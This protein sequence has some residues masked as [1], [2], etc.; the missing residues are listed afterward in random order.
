MNVIFYD[1]SKRNNS[2]KI[3]DVT[4]STLS[5]QIKGATSIFNPTLVILDQAAHLSNYCRIPDFERY[6]FVDN[7]TW[8]NGAWE[9]NLVCDV[10]ASYKY[11][12]E[13][14]VEY[15][16]RSS[17]TYDTNITDTAYLTKT[18]VETNMILLP[19]FFQRVITGGFYIIGIIGRSNTATQGA[20]TYYQ[21]T[22]AEMSRL[23]DYMLS[24]TFLTDQGL[25]AL[26]DF[27]PADATKV[28]YN[29]F[30][31]IVSC[32]WFPFQPSAIP[33][34]DKDSV[35]WID[36]G[37]WNTGSGYTAYKLKDNVQNYIHY[38]DISITDHPQIS[39]GDYMNKSPYTSRVLRFSP[40][41][42]VQLPDA[43]FIT[44]DKL[45]I[46]LVCDFITGSAMVNLYSIREDSGGTWR[47]TML[48][49]RLTQKLGVDIQLAQIG[50]D[51][52]GAYTQAFND[53]SYM[54]DNTIGAIGRIN[55]SSVSGAI[56]SGLSVGAKIGQVTDYSTVAL[57]NYMKAKAPQLM[58]SGSNGSLLTMQQYNYLC[59]TFYIQADDDPEQLGKPLCQKKRLGSIPGYI[60]VM[61]PDVDLDCYESERTLIAEFLSSGFW[62]E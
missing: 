11:D 60:V 12:I 17:N 56:S 49:T 23:R 36:F 1:F 45:R 37:W 19:E 55:L 30:Q 44:G 5:C 58:T 57:G 40:F 21:M 48:L 22:P 15:V 42:E 7:W 31:Y 9:C 32:M 2:T 35:T 43:Y 20:I 14:M 29:P 10:L 3:P 26:A 61:N 62:L 4:G 50:T 34:T 18:E 16:L 52:F 33:S 6:Y 46:E 25:V 13:Q 38:E 59:E 54:I 28:I 24:D 39:R 53:T 41:S 8:I 47:K 27:I 51:Y